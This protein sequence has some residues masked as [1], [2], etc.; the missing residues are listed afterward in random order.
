MTCARPS[1]QSQGSPT[2][3]V[4]PVTP[5]QSGF[6]LSLPSPPGAGPWQLPFLHLPAKSCH[7]QRLSIPFLAPPPPNQHQAAQKRGPAGPVGKR[8]GSLPS[9]LCSPPPSPPPHPKNSSSLLRR[10]HPW[11][12][13]ALPL[14]P[15]D[16]VS[17]GGLGTSRKWGG[18]GNDESQNRVLP[19]SR[20]GGGYQRR[21]R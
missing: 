4:V 17:P 19:A 15:P 5:T 12:H 21:L 3:C 2:L 10:A 16:S 1:S 13:M 9:G 7:L 18:G 11:V 20:G 14:G 6:F 8:V